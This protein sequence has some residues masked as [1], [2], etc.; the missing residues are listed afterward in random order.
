MDNKPFTVS[1]CDV[2]LQEPS[3][4]KLDLSAN[5]KANISLLMSEVPTVFAANRLENSYKLVFPEGIEGTLMELKRGG[6]TTSIKGEDGKIVGSA[7]LFDMKTEA[8]IMNVFSVMS[9]AV[10]QYF[11]C[12][13]NQ[14]FDLI[15]T[16]ID[17]VIGFLYGNK[18]AELLSDISFARYAYDNYR[19]IMRHD[20]QRIATIAGLQSSK[21]NAMQN[22]EFYMSDLDHTADSSE[23]SISKFE[24]I[25]EKAI[26]I[27]SCLNMSMQLLV[28]SGIMETFF[29]RNF[30][31]DY[32]KSVH[33][34]I[35]YYL[36]KCE[37]RILSNF[38]K[39]NNHLKMLK[40]MPGSK[41][42]YKPLTDA[43]EKIIEPLT[44][45]EDSDLLKTLS[46]LVNGAVNIKE[47]YLT[48]GGDVYIKS[49]RPS[50]DR[51][52]S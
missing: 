3:Y 24:T 9:F 43:F 16:K 18:K 34:S 8:A 23:K 21:K 39:L 42:D 7:A 14:K 25:A 35:A 15:S 1:E 40:P 36:N 46:V 52:C 17:D 11:L 50:G 38:S 29:S 10:G 28:V 31:K 48:K 51:I 26:K 6:F 49:A 13:I 45:G 32:L 22:I 37:K 41:F 20:A 5:E 2:N 4:H 12:E 44:K 19:S 47:C 33:D 27:C 30:D